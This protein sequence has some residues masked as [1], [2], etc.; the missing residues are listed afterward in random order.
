MIWPYVCPSMTQ[1]I[2]TTRMP[3]N[4]G[5]DDAGAGDS[6]RSMLNS[7]ENDS[8]S[9]IANRSRSFQTVSMTSIDQH[10]RALNALAST[11]QP[12]RHDYAWYLVEQEL[13]RHSKQELHRSQRSMVR[14]RLALHVTHKFP[15]RT[16]DQ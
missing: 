1:Q 15:L 12:R 13:Q 16:A 14:T 3:F 8:N 7:A 9:F 6:N 4:T 5:I 10:T 11:D 2:A